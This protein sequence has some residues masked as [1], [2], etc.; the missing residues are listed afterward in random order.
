MDRLLKISRLSSFLIILSFFFLCTSI[1]LLSIKFASLPPEVP[2]F[3]SRTWGEARLTQK[4]WLWIL[5]GLSLAFLLINLILA[6]TLL[7][8]DYFLAQVTLISQTIVLF[9][10]FWTLLKIV[11]LVG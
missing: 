10:L 9:L 3:Y 5:P 7:K 11:F 8:K 4:V 6:K 1:L 2:L